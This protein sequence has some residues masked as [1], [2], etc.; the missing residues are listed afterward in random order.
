MKLGTKSI[1]FGVHQFVLH[2]LLLAVAWWK[3]YGFPFDPRLWLAFFVH[4]LGYIGKPNMDGPE[5]KLHPVLGAM[6]M[7]TWFGDKWHDFCFY[8]SRYT[9]QMDRTSPSR[10]CVADKLVPC[11]MPVWLF[12]MLANLSGEIHE[13]VAEGLGREEN[14]TPRAWVVNIRT[15]LRQWVGD[16]KDSCFD[17]LG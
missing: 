13:Y 17:K 1:L 11:I 2:P 12:L 9:A 7:D 8:H 5:G 16:H 10:L 4:D 15:H 14:L 6:I 3:L